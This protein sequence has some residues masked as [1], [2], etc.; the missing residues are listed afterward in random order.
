[1]TIQEIIDKRLMG[2]TTLKLPKNF[3]AKVGGLVDV[4]IEGEFVELI[5]DDRSRMPLFKVL[6][7]E[8]KN[9]EYWIPLSRLKVLQSTNP[10]TG[11]RLI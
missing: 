6:G 4:R 11:E 7:G 3:I 10:I 1:M 2:D 5:E 9:K 8:F